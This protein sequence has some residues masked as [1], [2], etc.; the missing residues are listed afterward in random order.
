LLAFEA[1]PLRFDDEP[2]PWEEPDWSRL[3]DG[4]GLDMASFTRVPPAW[5][6]RMASDVQE[7]WEGTTPERPELM[8]RV[9]AAGYRGR[10]VSFAMFGPW[11]EPPK[12]QAE[13]QSLTS[14]LTDNLGLA[15]MVIGAL[16]VG[17]VFARRNVR[18]GRSDTRGALRLAFWFFLV[19][20]AVWALLA[21]H[22][23]DLGNEWYIVQ[24]DVGYNLF[25]A[26]NLWLLYVGLE[27]YVRRRWPDSII[28]WSRLLRGKLRDPLLGRDILV[29]GVLAGVFGM[30]E[31]LDKLVFLAMGRPMSEPD[32]VNWGMLGSVRFSIG[33]TIDGSIHGLLQVMQG[34]FIFLLLRIL[35][36]NVWL[37]GAVMIVLI[38][39]IYGA[40]GADEPIVAWIQAASITSVFLFVLVRYGLVAATAGLYINNTLDQMALTGDFTVWYAPSFLIPVVT[41]LALLG[42]GFYISLAGQPLFG[43]GTL[44][45][46]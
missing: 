29:G 34:L 8:L 24:A 15:V 43:T 31:H 11:V 39:L 36:R 6:P 23:Y 45:D 5:S 4:A 41:A 33:N 14:W 44:L 30:I 9:E 26:V 40:P 13:E 16:V 20:T 17:I 27:P 32:G 37:A 18:A 19:H 46:E 22:V 21:S 42:Y 25:L 35:L 1:I 38:G 28:S 2:G 10:P 3:F 7:A 12:M